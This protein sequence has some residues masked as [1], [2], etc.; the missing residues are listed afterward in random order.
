MVVTSYEIMKLCKLSAA[1]TLYLFYF[2][3][4][5]V[6]EYISHQTFL[7]ITQQVY[8][9]EQKSWAILLIFLSQ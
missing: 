8:W 4:L 7:L 5:N 1:K 3:L 9:K 6:T 2:C